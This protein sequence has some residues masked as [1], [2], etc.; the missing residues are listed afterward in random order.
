[1]ALTGINP[2]A[3]D[4]KI[5]IQEVTETADGYGGVTQTWAT[6]YN[7]RADRNDKPAGSDEQYEGAI[8]LAKLRTTYTI[9]H[10]SGITPKNRILDG[11]DVYDILFIERLG[12]NQHLKITT[13]LRT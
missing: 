9:R 10:I 1:M 11:G 7:V 13:E 4:T 3:F 2:G 8:N 12:R 5:E 6:I